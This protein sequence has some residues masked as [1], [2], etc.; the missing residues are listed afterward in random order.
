MGVFPESIS[1]ETYWWVRA[2][3][4]ALLLGYAFIIIRRFGMRTNELSKNERTWHILFWSLGPPILFF[5]EY[6]AFGTGKILPPPSQ[7]TKE[8]M[9]EMKGYSD[10]ASKIWAAVLACLLFLN[11]KEEK[12]AETPPAGGGKRSTL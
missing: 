12:K 1:Y 5:L 7:I 8:F 6:W 4:A 3:F 10:Y 11:P 2:F 9:S